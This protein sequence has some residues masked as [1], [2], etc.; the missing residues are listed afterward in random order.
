MQQ[1]RQCMS[2]HRLLLHQRSEL[3]RISA[4]N[5]TARNRTA[6]NRTVHNRTQHGK[7]RAQS[8]T[9]NP[10]EIQKQHEQMKQNQ[11]A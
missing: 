5:R 11:V 6:H 9:I 3:P 4:H 7:M 1:G 8:V 2:V 10:L